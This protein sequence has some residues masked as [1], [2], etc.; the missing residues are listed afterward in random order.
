MDHVRILTKTL[1]QTGSATCDFTRL[2]I[3]RTFHTSFWLVRTLQIIP[4]PLPIFFQMPDVKNLSEAGGMAQIVDHMP[5]K[6]KTLISKPSIVKKKKASK[7]MCV[8][9][10]CID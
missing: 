8:N 9:A 10:K 7:K 3:G 5:S 6:H 2:M 1:T 4:P